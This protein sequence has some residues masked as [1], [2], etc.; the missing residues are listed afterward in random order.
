MQHKNLQGK[1]G[2]EP[3]KKRVKSDK[4]SS[5]KKK[6]KK[7]E[8]ESAVQSESSASQ[9]IHDLTFKVKTYIMRYS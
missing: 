5:S 9:V 2:E 8:G 6:S 3:A 7:T 1:G 4:K